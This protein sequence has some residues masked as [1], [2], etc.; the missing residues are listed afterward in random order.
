[1][2]PNLKRKRRVPRPLHDELQDYASL[3]RAL[4]TTDP[5]AVARSIT[6]ATSP[7]KRRTATATATEK[8]KRKRDTWTRWPL[9]VNDITLPQFGLDDEIA[10]LA[11]NCLR[12]TIDPDEIDDDNN[13]LDPISTSAT[14]FL[15]ST[16]ALLAHHTPART[17]SMQDRL[18]PI[19]WRDVLDIVAASGDVDAT[20]VCVS[21][22]SSFS[23]N[24]GWSPTSRRGLKQSTALRLQGPTPSTV[25]VCVQRPSRARAALEKAEDALFR[26]RPVLPIPTC[27]VEP[28]PFVDIGCIRLLG[29]SGC[30]RG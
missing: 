25:C 6:Q 12:D 3:L 11:R 9:L 26:A 8:P 16:L 30:E 23:Y 17:Q 2:P 13:N 24:T 15:S 29:L 5:L 14:A 21:F 7:K 10:V 4:D 19:G 27:T 1:M 20:C 28:R 18:N 22:S